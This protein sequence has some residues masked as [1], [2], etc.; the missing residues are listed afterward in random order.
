MQK[1]A[2]QSRILAFLILAPVL[3]GGNF[4][5]GSLMAHDLPGLWTNLVRWLIA[6]VVLL[7]FCANSVWKHRVILFFHWRRLAVMALLGVTLFNTVLYIALQSAP[8]SIAAV[9]FAVTPFLTTG[10]SALIK[11]ERPPPR[12]MAAA[13]I[14]LIG[15]VLAQWQSLQ[16]GTP[17]MGMVLVLLAALIWSSYCVAL[18]QC[19]VPVPSR[20]SFFCQ[21]IC[22]T[23]FM[24]PAVAFIGMPEFSSLGPREWA[25]LGYLGIFAAALAFWLWQCAVAD[26]G[27]T[28]ASLFMN[29]VPI[30]IVILGAIFLEIPISPIEALAFALVFCGIYLSSPHAAQ[31]LKWLERDKSM[32]GLTSRSDGL[33]ATGIW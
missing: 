24:I 31:R 25:G 8:I 30:S 11:R 6:L 7:P 32:N 28:R 17:I 5:V 23:A 15:M 29:L 20:A 21:I 16:S 9:A 4:I 10:L 27:P 19:T 26:V 13:A 22:G 2:D 14:A 1:G 3:W 33:G 12:I 18:K